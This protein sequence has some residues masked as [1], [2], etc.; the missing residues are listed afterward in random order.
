MTTAQ[1]FA[2][3]LV[4]MAGIT[5]PGPDVFQ[6]IRRGS[7]NKRDGIFTAVGIMIGNALW[8]VASLLGL[9]ALISTY[10]AIL[11]TLQIVGGGYLTWMGIGAVRSWWSQR[12]TQQAVADAAA[13]ENTLASEAT[14]TG[15]SIGVWPALRAGIATNLSNPKAVLFFGSVF[16]QFVRPEMGTGWKV[17]VAVFLIIIGLIWFIGFAVLVQK[18]AA[19]ITRN[20][21]II[22]L[23]TGVIFIGLGLFMLAEGILG[24]SGA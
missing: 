20:S 19:V 16:A 4:W 2:L 12:S 21:A 24:I 8:I 18:V 10:P 17:F 14:A 11:N 9:S 22:D 7:R 6:I 1:L 3:F 13:V 5:S 15:I 23:I